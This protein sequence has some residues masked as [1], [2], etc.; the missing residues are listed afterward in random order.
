MGI[1]RPP[2][3]NLA[4]D[5]TRPRRVR[6]R[7]TTAPPLAPECTDAV[8]WYI[9]GT[10]DD[11]RRRR[12]RLVHRRTDDP[13]DLEG[14]KRGCEKFTTEDTAPRC[15]AGEQSTKT[16]VD[17][18][19]PTLA[20][21]TTATGDP[22][23]APARTAKAP[24]PGAPPPLHGDESLG[25]VGRARSPSA[26]STTATSNGPPDTY[27]GAAFS[28]V[29]V[30]GCRRGSIGRRVLCRRR[31]PRW[32]RGAPRARWSA[33]A[34]GRPGRPLPPRTTPPIPPPPSPSPPPPWTPMTTPDAHDAP[35]SVSNTTTDPRTTA[36]NGFDAS[37]KEEE[38]E[39]GPG[40]A[41]AVTH[42]SVTHPPPVR[43][44][45]HQLAQGVAD[46]RHREHQRRRFLRPRHRPAPARA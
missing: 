46:G 11:G 44:P 33:P 41:R 13:V 22:G 26:T 43:R 42:P 35:P 1:T 23:D 14:A 32:T 8:V 38:E 18:P 40:P 3:P 6:V 34:L 45:A 31:P 2:A 20:K 28:H 16:R 19:G 10:V 39:E 4:L 24:L 15:T 21:P 12:R 5:V 27:T 7:G 37:R 36:S 25:V 9:A 29:V 30:P 17:R